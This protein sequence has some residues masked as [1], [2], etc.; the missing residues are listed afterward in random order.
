MIVYLMLSCD[1]LCFSCLLLRLLDFFCFMCV[2]LASNLSG[3]EDT[4]FKLGK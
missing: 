1:E 3:S 4:K 2:E